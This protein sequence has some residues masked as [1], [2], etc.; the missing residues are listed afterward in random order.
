MKSKSTFSQNMD[1]FRAGIE[2]AEN[3]LEIQPEIV[4]LFSSIHFDGSA[5]LTEAIFDVI[6]SKDLLIIGCS[7]DGFYE[8][9]MVANVGASALAINSGGA[10]QWQLEY[11]KGVGL[12]PFET[13][14]RCMKRLEKACPKAR[15]YF[16]FSDFRTDASEIIRAAASSTK[17]PVIGG[18]ASDN[19]EMERCFVYINKEVVTDSVA[20]LALSGNFPFDIFTV[21]NTKPEGRVG[22]ITGCKG[23]AIQEINNMPA[24][25]FVEDA[26]GKPLEYIDTGTITGNVMS[27]DQPHLMRHRSLLLSKNP[28]RDTDIQLFGGMAK[29]DQIQLCL[30]SPSK[31]VNEVET[32]A[33]KLDQLEFQP[34]AAII[35]S[36][37]GRKQLLGNKNNVEISALASAEKIPEAIAGF[38]S[39][40]EISPIKTEQGYSQSLFHN[41]TYVLFAFGEKKV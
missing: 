36:C 13:T 7:G 19:F 18:M 8:R 9:N 23:T 2:I 5:E 38:P 3:L 14:I 39:L 31:I 28:G 33:A 37:A 4:F 11:E 27:P 24:M 20:M 32:V 10:I 30:T 6:D 25:Q 35:I 41:M 15:I 34:A 29:G 22:T 21:H 1:P 26:M 40:G 12:A 16:L 17:V